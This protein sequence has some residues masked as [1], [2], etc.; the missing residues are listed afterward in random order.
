MKNGDCFLLVYMINSG[1]GFDNV[2]LLYDCIARVKDTDRIAAVVVGNKVDLN[3]QRIV[4]TERGQE[5]ANKLGLP[6]I[7]TSAKTGENVSEAFRL[8]VQE[9]V[10]LQ[11]RT[12]EDSMDFKVVVMGNGGVGKSSLTVQYVQGVF[13]EKYDPTIEDSYRKLNEF[14]LQFAEKG[15]KKKGGSKLK[16]KK[17]P[18]SKKEN[19]KVPVEDATKDSKSDEEEKPEEVKIKDPVK[20]KKAGTNVIAMGLGSLGDAVV[21]MTG[22]P[23][24]CTKCSGALSMYSELKTVEKVKYWRCDFC[25]HKNQ[26]DAE[27]EELDFKKN[28]TVDYLIEV[29][30]EEQK[31]LN[32]HGLLVLCV[33]I[34][35][36]MCVTEPLPP[37]MNEWKK[38]QTKNNPNAD[39]KKGKAYKMSIVG[40]EDGENI[41]EGNQ[42]LPGEKR[43]ALYVSR[44]ECL[45]GA[46][47]WQLSRLMLE[48]PN[49]RVMLIT[50][51]HEVT[52]VGLDSKK[53]SSVIITGDKL[54]N[55]EFLFDFGAKEFKVDSIKSLNDTR[56]KLQEQLM[57]LAEG[58][59]TALGPAL[60]V[61][62]GLASQV[63]GTEIILCTDGLSNVGVGSFDKED[64]EKKGKK[65]DNA[66]LIA[67]FDEKNKQFYTRLGN[68]AKGKQT[69]VSIIGIEN[70][71]SGCAL[72]TLG[73][74]SD[75][76]SGTVNVL[77]PLE[78]I[79]QIV[80]ISQNPVIATS[81]SLKL[82]APRNFRWL[83]PE[84]TATVS[85]NSNSNLIPDKK[86]SKQALANSTPSNVPSVRPHI[87]EQVVGNATQKT[88]L[89]FE[90]EYVAKDEDKDEKKSKKKFGN[91]Q[92]QIY[93]MRLDGY[94]YLRVIT[95]Q[96]PL[97]TDRSEAEAKVDAAVL[98]LTTMQQT[99][100]LA[101]Q[102]KDPKAIKVLKQEVKKKL[103]AADRLLSKA[104][105]SMTQK[106]EY[107]NFI[108]QAQEL[109]DQLLDDSDESGSGSDE[110]DN[111]FKAK[112]DKKAK[113]V[114]KMK[115]ASK[116]AF[117]SG[118]RKEVGKRENS[119]KA[120]T[121]M[122]YEYT[123]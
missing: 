5:L 29:P 40:A 7:E 8:A 97:T 4:S 30:S 98:G 28:D 95:K 9:A 91:F 83:V 104:A 99:A 62:L 72:E 37:S 3:E 68:V 74:I 56:E 57:S 58:G 78:L 77:H 11:G 31:K 47:D 23:I 66:K 113:V 19:K 92:A 2:P 1:S 52:V 21:P 36:S 48:N 101:L 116:E 6:F 27:E 100:K 60:V 63:P 76:T 67:E 54:S 14:D 42:Y 49:K 93:Y 65:K 26:I 73:I 88:D 44:L 55:E 64:L 82:L 79:T 45:K 33:D 75:M 20:I 86:K 10:K 103:V 50:F 32:E 112:Q 17:A 69:K 70:Q 46:L 117:L 39:K 102:A 80:R 81:T 85:S 118:T 110:E 119:N 106:E 25:R 22:E 120:M 87:T 89:T 107:Y 51:N 122:Y 123:F 84:L 96:R 18:K 16:L 109:N 59:S 105:S 34:S 38:L 121:D 15:T 35:G 24:L 13:V 90:F 71:D 61:S 115:N 43:G 108:E 114:F 94:R 111:K 41:H 53:D 12:A